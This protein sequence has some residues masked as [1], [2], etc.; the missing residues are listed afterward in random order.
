MKIVNPGGGSGVESGSYAADL[1]AYC[2]G[3]GTPSVTKSSSNVTG[4]TDR[5]TGRYT[6][7]HTAL[8][9]ANGS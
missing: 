7:T 1:Y 5:A 4:I 9:S 6:I 2:D 8:A 3:T